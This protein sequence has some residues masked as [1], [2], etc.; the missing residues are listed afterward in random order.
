[1]ITNSFAQATKTAELAV[2]DMAHSASQVGHSVRSATHDA[3]DSLRG[4]T[5]AVGDQFSAA[6]ERGTR[7]VRDEP[8]KSVLIAAAAGATLAALVG[9]LVRSRSSQR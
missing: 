6:G 4:A 5:L 3:L 1:M 7:Y 2:A 8:V 9:W